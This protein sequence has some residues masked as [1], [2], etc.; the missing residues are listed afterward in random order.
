MGRGGAAM[1]GIRGVNTADFAVKV[2]N[3]SH[4]AHSRFCSKNSDKK[5]SGKTA[6]F[7]LFGEHTPERPRFR[8]SERVISPSRGKYQ[9]KI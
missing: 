6:F 2:P 1:P 9:K 3:F 5:T 8:L 7:F 4:L